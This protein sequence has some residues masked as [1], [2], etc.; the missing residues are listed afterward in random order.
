M[1]LTE[2]KKQVKKFVDKWSQEPGDEDRQ[3]QLFWFDFMRDVCGIDDTNYLE[4]EKP[5]K[6]RESDGK[7]HTRKIDVYVPLV[8]VIVEMKGSGIDLVKRYRQSGGDM[9]TPYEQVKRYSDNLP[10]SQQGRYIITCNFREF[11]IYDLNDEL[12]E[13]R[14]VII[15]LDE[16]V[17]KYQTFTGIFSY[18]RRE[19]DIVVEEQIST[20]AGELVGQLYDEL[21]KL[22]PD[23][24][25]DKNMSNL[26][27]K[28]LNILCVRFVFLFYAEDAGLFGTDEKL[29]QELVSSTPAKFLTDKF[30]T[31]FRV[32]NMKNNDPLR[33]LESAEMQAFPY[34]NGGLFAE[35]NIL[36]PQMTDPV[37]EFIAHEAAEFDWSPISP[38][39]F[40]AMFESTISARFRRSGGMHYT[41]IQ[42]IHKVIDP[43]FLDALTQEIEGLEKEKNTLKKQR[44]HGLTNRD[45]DILTDKVTKY[46]DKLAS[47]KILDASAGSGNFLT[48]SYLSLRRLENRALAVINGQQ[49][50]IGFDEGTEND[51]IKVHIDQF[52][53]IEISGFACD[54]AKT[55]LWIAEAQMYEETKKIVYGMKDDFLPLTSNNNIHHANALQI[56]WDD[57][58]NIK[59]LTYLIGNPPFVGSNVQ[60]PSQKADMKKTFDQYK[61]K[62]KKLDYVTAWYVKAAECMKETKLKA[63]L[64][65]TNSI[66]QGEQIPILWSVLYKLNIHINFAYRS[67][68]WDNEANEKAHVHCV[69]IGFSN[70]EDKKNKLLYDGN[71][72]KIA[73]HINGYLLDGPEIIVESAKKPICQ[74]VLKMVYGNKAYDKDKL[75]LNSDEYKEITSK[76]PKA[77]K[78]IKKLMGSREFIHNESR[79]CLWL[80]NCTPAE[81]K[82]MPPIYEKV[83]QCKEAR[84]KA[85]SK[86]MLELSKTPAVFR[87]KNNPKQYLLIPSTSSEN[88][89]YVPIGFLDRDTIPSNGTLVIPNAGLYELGV[90][91]SS[92]HMAWMRTVAGRLK[93]DYRYSKD[94]VYNNFPWPCVSDNQKMEIE[95]S[96]NNILKAR[97]LY[98]S[99]DLHSLYDSI[100]MPIELQKAHKAN[101]VVVMKAYGFDLNMTEN[102]IVSELLKMYQKKVEELE[103][104]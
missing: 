53:G 82:S 34:V 99:N 9:L 47:I 102:E 24:G 4:F 69:I 56:D 90:L 88:R 72:V 79:Y 12:P 22:Y 15:R 25:K 89:E 32:L 100:T 8:R 49:I 73:K 61:T 21:K 31:L 30:K 103:N 96:A 95:N 98:P 7:V 85:G 97:E 2:R 71:D 33:S 80:V 27:L 5:V 75:K 54:V 36:I 20:K 78:W 87:D 68:K 93:S 35:E 13:D 37:K 42:N 38:T 83:K 28:S 64:V 39:I 70:C 52:Y 10:R 17:E 23:A 3:S 81:I 94:I 45:I 43:L 14:P 46:Q 11:R 65:S 77:K 19:N 26:I 48:E 86:E 29:F 92:V 57:V 91:E 44:R 63:A 104:G 76:Y 51:P 18:S 16:L 50:S 84:L 58:I 40:G 66:T 67:F 41:S 59:Q 1:N 55:A 74:N 6:L 62:Y 101:D 60:S